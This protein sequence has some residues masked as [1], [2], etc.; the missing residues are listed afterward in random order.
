MPETWKRRGRIRLWN[1]GCFTFESKATTE[2]PRAP[3]SEEKE[4]RK[5]SGLAVAPQGRWSDGYPCGQ[6]L[7]VNA[8]PD[9][10]I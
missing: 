1:D 5:R 6:P 9:S 3:R 2:T 8:F 10:A 7:Y 4:M